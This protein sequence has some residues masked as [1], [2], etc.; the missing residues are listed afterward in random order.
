MEPSCDEACSHLSA[1]QTSTMRMYVCTALRQVAAIKLISARTPC[2]Q[3]YHTLVLSG[4]PVITGKN[5]S[6]AY[7]FVTLIDVLYE[8]RWVY[9]SMAD[10]TRGAVT[11]AALCG[12]R[13]S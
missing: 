13:H 8:H 3:K 2:S 11:D 9:S 12:C 6:E 4:V 7:R 5:R 10:K 1:H